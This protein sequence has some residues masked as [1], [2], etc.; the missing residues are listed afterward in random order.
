MEP[1]TKSALSAMKVVTIVKTTLPST[2]LS[3]V[4]HAPTLTPSDSGIPNSASTPVN[5]VSSHRPCSPYLK[6]CVV[7]VMY[8]VLAVSAKR[9]T[10]R[11][12]IS[13]Q[14]WKTYGKTNVS[15]SVRKER[16]VS[17]VFAHLVNRLARTVLDHQQFVLIVTAL[18]VKS[19]C[20]TI[21]VIRIAHS[22]TPIIRI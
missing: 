15:N 7:L 21:H 4:S 20:S 2:T 14:N 8:H 3:N 6:M 9:L 19:F 17:L 1:Q 13:S 10:V 12:V 22:N 11:A 16:L 5:K 18:L